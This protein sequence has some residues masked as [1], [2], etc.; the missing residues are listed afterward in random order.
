MSSRVV[1]APGADLDGFRRAVRALVAAGTPPD[2]VTWTIGDAPGLFGATVVADAPPVSLPKAVGTLVGD[3]VPH[4]DPE[5][6]AL[7]YQVIWR[8]THGER[9]L[10]EVASDPAVHRLELMR[11]SVA[12]DIHKMHAFLRFRRVEAGQDLQAP[13]A[14]DEGVDGTGEPS[15]AP[16]MDGAPE[17]FVAWFEPEHFISRLSRPSS[18]IASAPCAGRS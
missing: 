2:A 9:S 16:T 7:L 15:A 3:V 17:R 4:R 5:R 11:K 6:Y 13:D 10:L 8:V 12:R 1:L 18:S 14:E